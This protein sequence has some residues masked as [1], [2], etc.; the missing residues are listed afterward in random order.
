MKSSCC[1][2]SWLKLVDSLHRI[3]VLVLFQIVPFNLKYFSLFF[4]VVFYLNT[5]T[6]HTLHTLSDSSHYC[7]WL[8]VS[9]R[10]G[11]WAPALAAWWAPSCRTWGWLSKWK[12]KLWAEATP[13]RAF[14]GVAGADFWLKSMLGIPMSHGV[15]LDMGGRFSSACVALNTCSKLALF[16]W[17]AKQ[18]SVKYKEQPKAL[19]PRKC[20][21]R[22]CW[23]CSHWAG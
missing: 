18:V 15:E 19:S 10:K 2:G 4:H 9:P 14:S 22:W 5:V 6:I 3:K 16:S 8:K 11:L 13:S 7:P 21:G 17:I 23:P 12:N 1:L 20:I